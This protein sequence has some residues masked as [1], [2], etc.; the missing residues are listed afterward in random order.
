VEDTGADG[1][2][3]NFGCPHGMSERGMG[4]AV[5]QVP[6]YIQMVTA[7]CKHY[8]NAGDREAHAQHHRHAL[9]GARGQA[10]GAD[11]VSLINTINSI[12]GVDLDPDHGAQHRGQGLARRLLRPG[13]QARSR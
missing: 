12:M 2:E 1:I 13:G 8:S 5:G 10:G 3:L 6:E 11:A 9:P 4:A 7:W